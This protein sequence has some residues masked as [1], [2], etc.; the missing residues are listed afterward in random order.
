[1]G[2]GRGG[3]AAGLLH[4]RVLQCLCDGQRLAGMLT[5]VFCCGAYGLA[6]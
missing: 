6:G 2:L 4:T 1:M 3:E 5:T